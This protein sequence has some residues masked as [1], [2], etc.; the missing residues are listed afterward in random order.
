MDIEELIRES[1]KGSSKAQRMLMETVGPRINCVC[2]RYAT[3]G[4]T[5]DD[6]LQ[7]ALI[8]IFEKL[9]LYD[10][11]KGH[12]FAWSKTITIRIALRLVQ[13][14]KKFLYTDIE[15]VHGEEISFTPRDDISQEELLKIIDELEEPQRTI[16]NLNCIEGFQ[17]NEIA[18]MLDIKES[19]CRS[20]LRRAK[21]KLQKQIENW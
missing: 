3:G 15:E 21:I 2:F 14:N 4:V 10:P 16:F 18:E 5:S 20:H 13:Q 6:I 19:T 8:K 7:D 17:H 9:E 1:I 11:A 12:F